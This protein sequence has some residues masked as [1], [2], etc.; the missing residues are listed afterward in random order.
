MA[1]MSTVSGKSVSERFVQQR[2]TTENIFQIEVNEVA[3][4]AA[5]VGF[6]TRH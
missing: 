4:P 6:N 2:W 1:E 3:K 5:I